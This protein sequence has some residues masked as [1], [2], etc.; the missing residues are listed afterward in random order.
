MPF[1]TIRASLYY[2]ILSVNCALAL[3]PGEMGF[4]DLQVRANSLTESGNLI[5]AA[6]Y[7]KEIINRVE[8]S[9]NKEYGLPSKVNELGLKWNNPHPGWK[10]EYDYTDKEV[11]NYVDRLIEI[12]YSQL[13]RPKPSINVILVLAKDEVYSKDKERSLKSFVRKFA[14]RSEIL[15]GSNEIR[16]ASSKR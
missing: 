8:K 12:K 6:P 2:L 5:E 14:V 10:P 4:T 7:L 15:R 3:V 16:S 11:D 1:R 9:D 13:N